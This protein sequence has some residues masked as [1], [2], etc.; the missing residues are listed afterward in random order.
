MAI[1]AL[2]GRLP[3]PLAGADLVDDAAAVVQSD[4][5]LT[6]VDALAERLG[7]TVRTLQRRFVR[8]LGVGPKWVIQRQR[9]QDALAAIDAGKRVD[10]GALAVQLGFVDQ[11]HLTRTFTSLVGTS[12]AAYRENAPH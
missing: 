8:H 10:W 6:R 3:V 2:A 5:G 7:A 11:A 4:S 12:P 9:I 1:R